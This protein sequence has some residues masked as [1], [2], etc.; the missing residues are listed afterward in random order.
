VDVGSGTSLVTAVPF[1]FSGTPDRTLLE[2]DLTGSNE[3]TLQAGT[4]YAIDIRNTGSGSMYWMRDEN[5]YAGGNIYAQNDFTSP[6]QRFDVAGD[7]RR[8]G[9][10]ALFAAGLA[11]DFNQDGKVDAADYVTWRKN[12]ANAAL[13]NDNGAADQAARYALWRNNFGTQSSLGSGLSQAAVPE[14][15]TVVLLAMAACLVGLRSKKA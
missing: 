6:T 10:L 15:T 7:G 9:A 1:S 5:P 2:F 3:I 4:E 13:P 12:S 11:G 8:D 14:P